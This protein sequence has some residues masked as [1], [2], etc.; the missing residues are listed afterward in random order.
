MM[1]SRL[2]ICLE[3]EENKLQVLI[4]LKLLTHAKTNVVKNILDT[5]LN[6][7]ITFISLT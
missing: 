7:K 5:I 1:Q 6:E 4:Y 2:E 3:S